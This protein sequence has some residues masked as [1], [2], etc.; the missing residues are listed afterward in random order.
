MST[1]RER[2]LP[3]SGNFPDSY[4]VP[5]GEPAGTGGRKILIVGKQITVSEGHPFDR[6]LKRYVGGGPFYTSRV[7]YSYDT[8]NVSNAWKTSS[9]QRIYSGPVYCQFPTPTEVASLGG[10]S[11]LPYGSENQSGMNK[12]G[13]TAISLCNPVNPASQL[14][15]TLAETFRE[16]IPSIPGIQSWKNRTSVARAAG[17]EYLNYQFGWHPLVDEIHNVGNAARHHRDVMN[18][19]HHGAGRNTHRRFDFPSE[20]STTWGK[21]SGGGSADFPGFNSSFISTHAG[22]PTR[23]LSRVTERKRWFEGLF[24]YAVPSSTDSWRRLIGIGSEADQVFGLALTP[25]I[26]WELTP[27]SWAVDWVTN[28]GDV[29]KNVNNFALAGLV[30]RYGFMM[31][32]TIDKYTA[33]LDFCNLK[34]R[35]KDSSG[36]YVQTDGNKFKGPLTS[37]VTIVTKRRAAANPFG[38][39]LTWEGLSPTQLAIAA[40]VGITHLL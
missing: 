30:M 16:G 4:F 20:R 23:T 14:G 1:T 38:F 34:E 12:D 19:Y 31:E 13:A 18:Q 8:V 17:S 5:S 10:K 33:T 22:N 36:T 21:S 11:T 7:E 15:T 37:S 29:I 26:V 35:T 9:P 27:W 39:G 6:Q 2:Q 25:D 28:A 40:A 24:T 3:C 32:E